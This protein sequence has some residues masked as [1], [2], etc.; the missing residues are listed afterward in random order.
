MAQKMVI[1]S[2]SA[3]LV[4]GL[5]LSGGLYLNSRTNTEVN[6]GSNDDGRTIDVK[7]GTVVTVELPENPST[8]YSWAYTLDARVGEVI[9]D[10]FISSGDQ[11]GSGGMRVLKLQISGSGILAMEYVRPW[12]NIPADSYSVT[13]KV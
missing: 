13:F 2:F 9:A 10:N 1:A 8:G 6:L 4:V 11:L 5:V 7:A 12:E 3:I